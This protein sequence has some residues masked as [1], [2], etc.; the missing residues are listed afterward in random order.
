MGWR[1]DI[2]RDVK[3][4]LD[5]GLSKQVVFQS[6]KDRYPDKKGRRIADIVRNVVSPE[7][8]EKYKRFNQ[9]LIVLLVFSVMLK[10]WLGLSDNDVLNTVG[11][12][13]VL[14][15]IPLVY[16]TFVVAIY[17]YQAY[18]YKFIALFVLFSVLQDFREILAAVDLLGMLD[19]ILSVV[20]LIL[21]MYLYMNMFPAYQEQEDGSILFSE[22]ED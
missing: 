6:L 16:I 19:V 9:L 17:Y 20:I 10:K 4:S 22:E 1:K 11:T 5:K 15:A 8:K 12:L 14:V 18:F 7:R 3:A 2:K 13:T 21:S